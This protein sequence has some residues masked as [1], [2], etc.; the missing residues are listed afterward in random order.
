MKRFAQLLAFDQGRFQSDR[1]VQ[2]K[3]FRLVDGPHA[4]ATNMFNA[5]IA[6]LKQRVDWQNGIVFGRSTRPAQETK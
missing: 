4:A 6:L 1:H 3:V 5:A 2:A